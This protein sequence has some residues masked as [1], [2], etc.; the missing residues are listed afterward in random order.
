MS[1]CP[2]CARSLSEVT[3]VYSRTMGVKR[4]EDGNVISRGNA[5]CSVKCCNDMEV[6]NAVRYLSG[7]TKNPTHRCDYCQRNEL[8]EYGFYSA[9]Y[10]GLFFCSHLCC[11]MFKFANGE[12]T[13]TKELFVHCRKI[14][15]G[16]KNLKE[17][18]EPLQTIVGETVVSK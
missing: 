16:D 1:S 17:Q 5:Y 9:T 4:D 8:V 11:N 7:Q 15:Y 13:M 10:K 6:A 18:V 14:V 12:Q 2:S 3:P